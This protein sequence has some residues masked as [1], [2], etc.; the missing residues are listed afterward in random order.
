MECAC[1]DGIIENP[2]DVATKTD[3]GEGIFALVLATG[4]E[5]AG[6][7]LSLYRYKREGH[8]KDMQYALLTQRGRPIRILRSYTLDS[9]YAPA[10]GLRYDGL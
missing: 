2:Y 8:R 6:P 3:E 1:R 10:A 7:G 9:P 4:K 5:E